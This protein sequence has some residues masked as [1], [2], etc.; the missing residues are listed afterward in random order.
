MDDHIFLF[1]IFRV[2]KVH[3]YTHPGRCHRHLKV[4]MCLTAASCLLTSRG[5]L[6]ASFV[7]SVEVFHTCAMQYKQQ[8]ACLVCQVLRT[9]V[10]MKFLWEY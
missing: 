6:L 4:L 3:W 1:K 7:T 5:T 8:I 9:L 10:P 2:S